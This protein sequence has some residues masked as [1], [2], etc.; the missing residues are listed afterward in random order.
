MNTQ[1]VLIFPGS[2]VGL[3]CARQC[4]HNVCYC[5]RGDYVPKFLFE[6]WKGV[7][8]VYLA[9]L[10]SRAALHRINGTDIPKPFYSLQL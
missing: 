7:V 3:E 8:V 4:I 2:R 5:G 9:S 1:T 6:V 10:A